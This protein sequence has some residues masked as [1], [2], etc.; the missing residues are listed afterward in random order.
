[1]MSCCKP[2]FVLNGQNQAGWKPKQNSMKN[3]CLTFTSADTGFPIVVGGAAAR[4]GVLPHPAI[5]FEN[6]PLKTDAPLWG[7]LKLKNEARPSEKQIPPLKH[8]TPL[9]EMIPRKSTINNNFKSSQNP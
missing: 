8:E 6:P 3:T 9:H 5:F 7:I 4:A 1:M 2:P